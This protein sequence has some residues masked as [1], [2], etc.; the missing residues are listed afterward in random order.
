MDGKTITGYVCSIAWDW[1]AGG[2]VLG[3][4]IYPSLKALK[5]GHPCWKNCGVTAISMKKLGNRVEALPF[6]MK[7]DDAKPTS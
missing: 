7:D 4:I 1:E 5:E 6:N 3:M 2:C